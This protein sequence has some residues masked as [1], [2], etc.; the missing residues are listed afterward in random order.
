F[1]AAIAVNSQRPLVK[2]QVR[3]EP[4]VLVAAKFAAGGSTQGLQVFQNRGRLRLLFIGAE[5]AI[6]RVH[7]SYSS[8]RAVNSPPRQQGF[9]YALAGPSS[10]GAS[11]YERPNHYAL[12]RERLL[13]TVN[14][15]Q[16]LGIVPVHA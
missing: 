2:Y 1:V 3:V 16:C 8:E 11:D 12:A 5:D 14:E 7:G 13:Q 6:P 4:A 9:A 10:S 15:C